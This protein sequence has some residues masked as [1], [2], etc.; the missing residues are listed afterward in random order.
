M[1]PRGDDAPSSPRRAVLGASSFAVV[2]GG[3]MVVLWGLGSLDLEGGLLA[4]GVGAV[5]GIASVIALTRRSDENAP[6]HSG[7]GA[8]PS[9]RAAPPKVGTSRPASATKSEAP[10]PRSGTVSPSPE[11][12][13]RMR[14]KTPWTWSLSVP[15]SSLE[16]YQEEDVWGLVRKTSID[17][18]R[19]LLF[20]QG[21][22]DALLRD[23][24]LAGATIY[25]VSRMEGEHIVSPADVDK[26]GDMISIHFSKGKGRAVVLPGLETVV[27]STNA[28]NVRRLLDLVRDL[29]LESR[30]TVLFSV[31]PGSLSA[32]DLT[33]LERGSE[34]LHAQAPPPLSA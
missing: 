14:S 17:P 13:S 1:T 34:Q 12:A 15:L 2:A 26:L 23:P 31:D 29:A 25:K 9:P 18:T 16:T 4:I 3:F 6:V 32:A 27:E 22:R 8:I 28:R 30:G 10:A 21:S 11:A 5:A 19:L 20:T 24:R 33:L 7:P